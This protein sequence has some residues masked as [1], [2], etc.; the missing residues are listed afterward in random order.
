VQRVSGTAAHRRGAGERDASTEDLARLR[1]VALS[2]SIERAVDAVRQFLEMDVAFVS[3]ITN[4]EQVYGL[5]KGDGESFGMHEGKRIPLRDT[6]CHRILTGRL[7]NVIS[8][9]RADDR[10]A[11]L[12]VTE[13]ADVGAYVAV[14][15]R[16]ADG[17]LHGTLCAA[18]HDSKPTLGYRELQFLHVF[19]RMVADMVER[20]S[21][22]RATHELELQA[23]AAQTLIAAVEARDSYTG[24]HS[25]KV[26]SHAVEVARRLGLREPEVDRVRHVAM[27]HDIGKIAIPDT[28]LLKPGP[29]EEGE[30]EVMRSHSARGEELI[31]STPGLAHLASAI[32]S[33]HERWDGKGYPDGLSGEE[34]PLESRITFVC[35][36]YH[37]MTSDRPYR[38]A[39]TTKQA[40]AEVEAGIG[41]QFCPD[42]ARALLEILD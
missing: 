2:P 15:I 33:E 42:S 3:E 24:E 16:F 23:A 32:R 38:A 37:A 21:T 20:E 25:R 12:N 4:S 39:L 26:V 18:S 14:P 34:I 36:A 40:R 17:R 28:V 6:Y 1:E 5:M 22:E 9:V 30:L 8:D 41:S 31:R 35:D 10:A 11:S 7:P 29:L 13:E 27:L 19:A